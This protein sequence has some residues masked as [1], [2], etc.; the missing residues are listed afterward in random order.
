[1]IVSGIGCSVA[2]RTRRPGFHD[3]WACAI[4]TGVKLTNPDLSVRVVTGDGALSAATI[5]HAMR[6]NIDLKV[7]MFNNRIMV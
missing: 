5:I 3:P 2:S 4:A 7:M 6:R 1:M